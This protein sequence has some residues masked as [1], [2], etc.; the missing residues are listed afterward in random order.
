MK[1]SSLLS[2]KELSSLEDTRQ[3]SLLLLEMQREGASSGISL[4]APRA[5]SISKMEFIVCWCVV[6]CCCVVVLLHCCVVAVPG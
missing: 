1:P 4:A 6:L 3:L 2:D 5:G